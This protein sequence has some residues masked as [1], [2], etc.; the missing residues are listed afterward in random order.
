MSKSYWLDLFTGTTWEEFLNYGSKVSGFRNRM[1][2]NVSK[3]KQGDILLCY[4]TGVMRWIG[5]LEVLG[6]SYDTSKIW[7][8]SDFPERLS[9]KPIVTLEP[10]NGVPMDELEGHVCFYENS[11]DS[12]KFKGF[13]RMSP[14]LF[15]MHED[16]EYILNLLKRAK[17]NPK[18]MPIDQQK[19]ERKPLYKAKTRKGKRTVETL[20][21]IPERE[22][23][24]NLFQ[25]GPSQKSIGVKM[26]IGDVTLHTDIQHLLINLGS[27]LSLN[28]W[29]A[30][31]DRSKEVD[32]KTF[33]DMP[34]TV[35]ELPTQF[36]TTTNKVIEMIDVLW[37][38]SNRIVAAFEIECTTSVY[39]GLLR[40]SDLLALQPNIN[41]K[42]YIVAP[43][44]RRRKVRDEILRPTFSLREKPISEVCG[45]LSIE[46]LREK[47]EGLKNLGLLS[48]I[49]PNFLDEVAGYFAEED[50]WD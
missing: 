30:R 24:E 19:W 26:P 10:E 48:S 31:N 45:F 43:E 40:M 6:S 16:G 27:E 12:G 38:K 22:D 50:D 3:I 18:S 7:K 8:D 29:V 49:R 28:V 17:N 5:A 36:D 9:V 4:V 20:V 33:Q 37:L 35:N 14:N 32:G 42:L 2:N 13:V 44:A 1:R 34:N 41:I 15:R 21:S 25:G 39:S 46:E 11:E 47:I 23:E